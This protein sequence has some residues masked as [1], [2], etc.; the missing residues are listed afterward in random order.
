MAEPV[1]PSPPPPPGLAGVDS[2]SG[3]RGGEHL[4]VDQL[5]AQK[6]RLRR[7]NTSGL[8]SAQEEGAKAERRGGA[9]SGGQEATDLPFSKSCGK[10]EDV[11]L[12]SDR[13]PIKSTPPPLREGGGE[14]LETLG[15]EKGGESYLCLLQT[16]AT[17]FTLELTCSLGCMHEQQLNPARVWRLLDRRILP[18]PY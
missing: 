5:Q 12:L 4:R 11:L 16:C 18:R 2:S 1:R 10:E 9:V 17:S 13:Q 3:E 7:E 6:A 15:E 8:S 14:S